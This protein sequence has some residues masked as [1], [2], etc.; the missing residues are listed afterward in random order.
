MNREYRQLWGPFLALSLAACSA[1][2]NAPMTTAVRRGWRS[3]SRCPMLNS[4]AAAWSGA[5]AAKY[6]QTPI[7]AVMSH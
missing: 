7:A 2:N 3:Y 5:T 6:T 4:L 1:S